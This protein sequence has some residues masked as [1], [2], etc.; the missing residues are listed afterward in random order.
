MNANRYII[1]W[2]NHIGNYEG[3]AINWFRS[4]ND[5]HARPPPTSV[6]RRL[7]QG[8]DDYINYDLIEITG[9]DL[10]LYCL[11]LSDSVVILF[12]GGIKTTNRA[13]DCPNVREDF[14]IANILSKKITNAIINKEIEVS[15]DD[16]LYDDDFE[17]FF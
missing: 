5:A 3:A 8:L 11:R 15:E 12:N 1:D 2:I 4:E 6:A 7:Q 9:F 17:I 16:I 10:R 13:Q 14:R